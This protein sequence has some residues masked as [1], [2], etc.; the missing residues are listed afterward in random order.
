MPETATNKKGEEKEMTS[1]ER[2][3]IDW[4]CVALWAFL[5]LFG[6]IN[7]YAATYSGEHTALFDFGTF[8]GKQMIWIAASAL[9]AIVLMLTEPRV[10]SNTAYI[11]YGVV[12]ALLVAT[13]FIAVTSH[14]GKSWID[15]GFFR[16]QPSEFAK[17]ATALAMAKYMSAIDV[18]WKQTRTKVAAAINAEP[19][20]IIFTGCG[21]ES[22]NWALRGVAKMKAAKGRHII[23]SSIEHHAITHTLDD[24]KNTWIAQEK[25]PC[26]F[27]SA[28][29][30]TNIEK[31]RNDIYK[32]V[33][34]IHAGRYPFN[35]F[36]W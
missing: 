12:M 29:N 22:D 1:N 25:T 2:L 17:F 36:L 10:F 8:H 33:A 13:L 30:K 27:M 31:L 21:T 20:E 16:L 11:V 23:T 28:I 3:K 35:N 6:W 34:E 15:L 18:D 24:L 5:V 14:G 26:I 32:M 7:I 9:V 19:T 4:L